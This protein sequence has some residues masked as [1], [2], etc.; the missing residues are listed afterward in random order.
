MVFHFGLPLFWKLMLSITDTGWMQADGG[1]SLEDSG[2]TKGGGC[3][4]LMH[5]GIAV[6]R[7][8]EVASFLEVSLLKEP[9]ASG[10]LILLPAVELIGRS[11]FLFVACCP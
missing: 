7:R 8:N 6:A 3:Y 1:G 10:L 4:K 2:V 11:P 9:I 5:V